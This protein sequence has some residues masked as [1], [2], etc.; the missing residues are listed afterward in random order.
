MLTVSQV[1]EVPAQVPVVVG[2]GPPNEVIAAVVIVAIVVAGAVLWPIV[3]A[4]A[5]RI[6]GK[7]GGVDPARVEDLEARVGELEQRQPEIAELAER[8]DF[9][10]RMLTRQMDHAKLGG[11][12]EDPGGPGGPAAAP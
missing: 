8:V 5:R 4:W 6:E 2:S 9:A 10:E 1:V 7:S 12:P 3:R 11:G